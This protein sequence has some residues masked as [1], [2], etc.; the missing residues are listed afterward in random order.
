MKR[1]VIISFLSITFSGLTMFGLTPDLQAQQQV[2][3]CCQ[4]EGDEP[5]CWYPSDADS[6]ANMDGEYIEGSKNCDLNTG[7]CDGYKKSGD[8]SAK[9]AE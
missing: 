9:P 5:G 1:M 3:G 8:G 4:F 2:S 6:C 7:Y